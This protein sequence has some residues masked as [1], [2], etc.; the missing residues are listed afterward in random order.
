MPPNTTYLRVFSRIMVA[1]PDLFLFFK[2]FFGGA[3]LTER[4][5]YGY[6]VFLIFKYIYGVQITLSMVFLFK[7]MI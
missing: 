1:F 5:L 7:K 6:R 2:K 4:Y 3:F